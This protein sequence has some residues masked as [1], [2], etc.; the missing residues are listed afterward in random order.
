MKIYDCFTFYNELDLLEIR[1]RELYDWVDCFVVVESNQTF[2]NRPKSYIYEQARA[3][4]APWADKIR[5]IKHE[6]NNR[7][8][9]WDNETE[10]RDAILKGLTDANDGDLVLIGDA[11]EIPRASA[12][13][14]MREHN[15]HIF[16]GLR[17]PLFNFKF[18]YMRVT[19]GQYDVWTMGI[20]AGYL[21]ENLT[22]NFLRNQR[23]ELNGFGFQDATDQVCMV[24]H[25]GWHFGY[26]GDNEYLR[27]KAQSFSHQE[28]NH[29]EFLESIDLDKSIAE[30]KEWDRTQANQYEIVELDTYFPESV[31][32]FPGFILD[33]S[34]A[35]AYNLLPPFPYR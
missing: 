25:A 15:T 2:T 24:E 32:K 23:F 16:Y 9:P 28:V 18:N 7:A 19:P 29:P 11:D 17:M 10:Q 31:K 35:N 27:D 21:N 6:S 12:V 14:Y 33:N 4:F 3:R 30:R 34:V 5:Y 8:N 1:L 13:N 26:L 22:P 20:M